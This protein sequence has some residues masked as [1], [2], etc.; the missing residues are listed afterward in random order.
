MSSIELELK[1]CALAVKKGLIEKEKVQEA[2]DIKNYY[3]EKEKRN[4]SLVKILVK[5]GYIDEATIADLTAPAGPPNLEIEHVNMIP[6]FKWV[7]K[8]GAGGMAAVFKCFEQGEPDP[9]AVKVMYPEHTRNEEFVERF[10]REAELLK[11][12]DHQGIVKGYDFGKFRRSDGVM[13]YWVSM[14]FLDGSSVLDQLG[15]QGRLDEATALHVIR[16][17]CDALDYCMQMGILHR[18]VKPE[19][20]IWIG[21]EIVLC[22]LGFAKPIEKGKAGER[23]QTTCGTV[24][25]ISPEQAKGL[26]DVDIRADIY[27]LGAT[28]YH[29]VVGKVPFS[30][31]DGGE[32]MKKQVKDPL[33]TKEFREANV[34]PHMHYFIEKMMAKDREE[35]F[36]SPREV[37]DEI[38]TVIRGV[39]SLQFKPNMSPSPLVNVGALSTDGTGTSLGDAL[40]SAFS[41]KQKPVGTSSGS[42]SKLGSLSS[43]ISGK[44]K[45]R[46][47]EDDSSSKSS[48]KL[49]I[50]GTGLSKKFKKRT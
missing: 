16:G 22:D 41:G 35:R 33:S 42:S 48:K 8:V 14:E 5:K 30:G 3:A 49:K 40:K 47:A 21:D 13:L 25:Y 32:I 6:N 27:S 26:A 23:S 37:V 43:K 46:A 17:C 38:D 2:L 44:L 1:I 10:I 28:L 29:L 7:K 36:Q 12:F 19:N 18:D 24:Q 4:L 31:S 15:K 34:S 50:G 9:V 45:A 11:E 39:E 20:I